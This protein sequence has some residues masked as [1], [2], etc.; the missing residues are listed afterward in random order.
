MSEHQYTC[1]IDGCEYTNRHGSV[2][3][4]AVG[5]KDDAHAGLAYQEVRRSL[6]EQTPDGGQAKEP[7]GTADEADDM[8]VFD[9]PSPDRQADTESADTAASHADTSWPLRGGQTVAG[10]DGN[11]YRTDSGD[12]IVVSPD[13]DSAIPLTAGQKVETTDGERF[14]TEQGDYLA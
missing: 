11:T 2:I 14:Q 7:D 9:E 12:R 3:A 4:H 1:P 10:T 6:D 5:K 13:D 8:S